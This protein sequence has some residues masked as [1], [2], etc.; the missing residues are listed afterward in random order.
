L[1]YRCSVIKEAKRRAI[2]RLLQCAA[3]ATQRL[4]LH[5]NRL[6]TVL[7]C[8]RALCEGCVPEDLA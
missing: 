8:G 2:F 5:T 7:Q 3:C 1:L 4:C 6:R